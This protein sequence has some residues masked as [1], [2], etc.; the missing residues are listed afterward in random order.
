MAE[1]EPE[2]SDTFLESIRRE[3]EEEILWFSLGE[4][5]N[6]MGNVEKNTVGL[7]FLTPTRFFFQTNPKR[8]FFSALF[9]GFRRKSKQKEVQKLEYAVPLNCLQS[10][11]REKRRGLFGRLASV[12]L[13]VVTV[14]VQEEGKETAALR[15]SLISREKAEGFF[16]ALERI[17]GRPSNRC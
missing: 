15:F 1:M 3:V 14:Q 10:A 16:T 6:P 7:F 8:D 13:P 2:K 17:G 4:N 5:L 12:S 11:E 9:K